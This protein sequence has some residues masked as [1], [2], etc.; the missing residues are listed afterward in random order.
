MHL[1]EVQT[2]ELK[3]KLPELSPVHTSD[4]DEPPT[5]QILTHTNIGPIHTPAF[6][7]DDLSLR[8]IRLVCVSIRRVQFS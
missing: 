6:A 4:A 2:S 5:A 7:S 3:K 1:D 8:N